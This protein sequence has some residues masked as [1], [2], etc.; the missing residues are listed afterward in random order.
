M[1]RLIGGI[2]LTNKLIVHTPLTGSAQL[3]QPPDL[4]RLIYW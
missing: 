2:V 1:A 3:I 4:Q